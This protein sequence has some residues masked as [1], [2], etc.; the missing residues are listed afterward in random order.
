MLDEINHG[1]KVMSESKIEV[2]WQSNIKALI[3][4]GIENNSLGGALTMPWRITYQKLLDVA[5]V[6]ARI[7]DPELNLLMCELA[8]Y[9]IGDGY[10]KDY[11]P[12][13]VDRIREEA[14]KSRGSNA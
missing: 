6:A 11:D 2:R 10:H 8:L 12:D 1:I 14:L 4:E 13:L 3:E 7:N 9:T 5:T